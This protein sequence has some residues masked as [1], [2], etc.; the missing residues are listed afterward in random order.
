[1]VQDNLVPPEMRTSF[2]ENEQFNKTKHIRNGVLLS[3]GPFMWNHALNG[4]GIILCGVGLYAYE[5]KKILGIALT[6][7]T[8][9]IVFFIWSSCGQHWFIYRHPCLFNLHPTILDFN[10]LFCQFSVSIIV[11]FFAL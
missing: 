2:H 4:I 8:F 1:V 7:L 6:F 9:L 3:R 10:S 5:K 11:I